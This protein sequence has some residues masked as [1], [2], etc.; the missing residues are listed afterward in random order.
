MARHRYTL[1]TALAAALCYRLITFYLPPLW[2]YVALRS[3]RRDG[4]L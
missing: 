1:T 4:Y 3:L 2:G